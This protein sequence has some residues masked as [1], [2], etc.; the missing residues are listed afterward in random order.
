[1]LPAR[2]MADA[3]ET[4]HFPELIALPLPSLTESTGQHPPEETKEPAARKSG[5]AIPSH[6]SLPPPREAVRHLLTNT[7]SP[8]STGIC[9][10]A[11]GVPRL[12]GIRTPPPTTHG[13]PPGTE[14]RGKPGSAWAADAFTREKLAQ[15]GDRNERCGA[16]GPQGREA[17]SL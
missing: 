16:S 13:F 6:E 8:A 12:G 5:T 14:A 17:L 2:L 11:Q 4:P 7:I 10:S 1:M 3:Q 9:A 15:E